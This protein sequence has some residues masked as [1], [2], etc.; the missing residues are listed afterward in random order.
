M[1]LRW[2]QG[3]FNAFL[4]ATVLSDTEAKAAPVAGQAHYITDITLHGGSSVAGAWV[5]KSGTTTLL[6]VWTALN[7]SKNLHFRVPIRCVSGANINVTHS[8]STASNGV[9]NGFTDRG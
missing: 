6:T 2:I 5:I 4:P 3:G 8:A 9:I 7:E 1:S